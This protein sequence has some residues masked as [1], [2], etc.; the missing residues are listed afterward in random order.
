V[1]LET[2]LTL[3]HIGK[4]GFSS[5]SLQNVVRPSTLDYL[6][7][8]VLRASPWK[9]AQAESIRSGVIVAQERTLCTM[10]VVVMNAPQLPGGRLLD[11]E[12]SHI[13]ELKDVRA[14][15][16]DKRGLQWGVNCLGG[17]EKN[18]ISPRPSSSPFLM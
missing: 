9:M 18:S 2:G 14:F 6:S 12:N 4:L 1:T 5:T 13:K 11:G 17:A 15:R 16:W 3:E 7:G 8:H 10:G